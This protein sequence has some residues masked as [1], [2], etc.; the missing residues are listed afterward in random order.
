MMPHRDRDDI[1]EPFLPKACSTTDDLSDMREAQ[2]PSRRLKAALTGVVRSP[3][4]SWTLLFV[5]VVWVLVQYESRPPHGPIFPQLTY[6]ELA[7]RDEKP[8]IANTVP[9]PRPRHTGI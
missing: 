6:S 7:T 8:D 3:L 2:K 4:L 9:R 1:E 5:V